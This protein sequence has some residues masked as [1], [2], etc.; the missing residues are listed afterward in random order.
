MRRLLLLTS[1]FTV[2]CAGATGGYGPGMTN[3]ARSNSGCT[4]NAPGSSWGTCSS[5]SYTSGKLEYGIQLGLRAG[6][7]AASAGSIDSGTALAMEP[8]VDIVVASDRWGVGVTT[9]YTN[10]HIFGSET[11]GELIYSGFPLAPYGQYG[12][13]RKIFVHAG[14]GRIGWGSV[15][16]TLPDETTADASAWRAFGGITFVFK[17]SSS[18][19]LALRLEARA[20]RS[21]A[22]MLG[23][24]DATWSSVGVLAEII[25]ASF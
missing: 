13:T 24:E 18:S 15:K 6:A 2:G 23:G 17:R 25:W 8:H 16:R 20:Q 21:S 19:D 10:E 7:A 14:A 9:G 12:L 1:A 22:V 5:R 11:G 3:E 4:P